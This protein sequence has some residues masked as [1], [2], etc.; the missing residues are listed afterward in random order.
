ME[1]AKCD[2]RY[3]VSQS[4]NTNHASETSQLHKKMKLKDTA[5]TLNSSSSKINSGV[6]TND[7]D[8]RQDKI[9]SSEE[10][11]FPR[12]SRNIKS[13]VYIHRKTISENSSLNGIGQVQVKENLS[14]EDIKW[15][16][17]NY[18]INQSGKVIFKN[19]EPKFCRETKCSRFTLPQIKKSETKSNI[20][21]T[22]TDLINRVQV[23]EQQLWKQLAEMSLTSVASSKSCARNTSS[24]ENYQPSLINSPEEQIAVEENLDLQNCT[25]ISLTSSNQRFPLNTENIVCLL[26]EEWLNDILRAELGILI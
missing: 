20:Y 2:L 16:G 5:S 23:R 25:D 4:L 26:G 3:V 18:D 17:K 14:K 9:F 1:N 15:L 11:I 21:K 13:K 22:A 24:L 19:I 6:K 8:R 10:I 12:E 7:V